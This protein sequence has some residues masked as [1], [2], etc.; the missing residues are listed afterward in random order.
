MTIDH[1]QK[2]K[3]HDVKVIP[4]QLVLSFLSWNFPFWEYARTRSCLQLFIATYAGMSFINLGDKNWN[5]YC[6]L[7][8]FGIFN[9]PK[10]IQTPH[11]LSCGF[12]GDTI[13]KIRWSDSV[14]R[15]SFSP[16]RT[17]QWLL[18]VPGGLETVI[19]S[20][21]P[22]AIPEGNSRVWVQNGWQNSWNQWWP[23]SCTASWVGLASAKARSYHLVS[24]SRCWQ[25]Q[26]I[27]RSAATLAIL[28]L[29][30]NQNGLNAY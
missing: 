22:K 15:Q 24:D 20:L 17:W 8:N 26:A 23:C 30:E 28:N 13:I 21:L 7:L 1:L 29:L 16:C 18:A 10:R 2:L 6:A 25:R 27:G 19:W 12:R 14:K 9:W 3:Y 11:S 4:F 5:C